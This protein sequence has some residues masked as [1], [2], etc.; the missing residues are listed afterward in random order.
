M[1][2]IQKNTYT[3][4]E[5]LKANN[6]RDW[7]TENKP[8]YVKA[9]QNVAD[10][11]DALI[12]EMKKID[13]IENESGK[14]S[15]FRIYNDVRFSKGKPPYKVHFGASLSRATRWLRGGYYI[16]FEPG[17]TFIGTGFWQPNADDIKLI[18]D[19]LSHDST[20]FR[21]IIDD[22]TFRS[23]WGELQG[24]TV[25]TAP[26]GYSIDDPN[27]DLIRHKGFIFSKE[28]SSE[29]VFSEDF[30]FEVT[31]SFLAIRPFF[32]YMSEVLT[33]HLEK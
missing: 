30:V 32:D 28:F 19:E 31:K 3:F 27:I 8:R 25:K 23:I 9:H 1:S 5:E 6:N 22:K 14:K 15:L 13:N 4:L 16:H 11:M 17:N 21:E 7:F 26:R 24:E 29:E 10:F 20:T 18:R 2:H 12:S 33:R